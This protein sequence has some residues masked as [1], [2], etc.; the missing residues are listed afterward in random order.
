[1]LH[2]LS[3]LRARLKGF[4]VLSG[5]SGI[6]LISS[7]SSLRSAPIMF[8]PP[9][10]ATAVERLDPNNRTGG[11]GEDP[12][13][14]N[15]NVNIPVV[16]LRGRAELNLGLMLSYNSLVWTRTG[17]AIVF[18]SDNGFPSAGF[19]LGFPVIQQ[20]YFNTE[21]GKHAYLLINPD[22]SRIELRQVGSSVLFESGD[23]SH[24]LF[25]SFNLTLRTTDGAQLKYAL[26]GDQFNCTQIKD[27]NGNFITVNYLNNRIDTVID[28]LGRS[29]KFNYATNGFLTSITQIWNHGLANQSTHTWAAFEYTDLTIQTSFSS[30]LTVHGPTTAKLLTR[31][32]MPDGT[33]T[34][35]SYTSWGQ[36]WKV[37][38]FLG[39][40]AL[41]HQSYDVPLTAGT[42]LSDCP[43]FTARRDWARYWNGDTNGTAAANEEAV[44]SFIAPVGDSWTMPDGSSQTGRRAQVTAPDG[45]IDKIYF[46]GAAA[47]S[48]GWRRGLVALIET[49]NGGTW[50]RKVT[51]SW[52]QD[53]TS[54]SYP[55]NPREI[56]TNIYDPSGNRKRSE[57]TY[58]QF[59][60]SN[61]TSCHLPRDLYEYAANASTRLRSTRT[62]YNMSTSYTDRRIL[63]L[64]SERRLYQ[65]DVNA[66]GTLKARVAFFYDNENGANSIQGNNAPIQHDNTNYTSSFVTGR[67]NNSS[68]RR[69]N[70]D[71]QSQFTTSFSKYNTAGAVVSTKDASNHEVTISYTDSFSDGILR[72][73]LAYPTSVTDAD[74]FASTR[75][76]NF[77]FGAV[78]AAQTPQPNGTTNTPGP[79]QL[80]T[81]DSIGRLQ[82]VS[83]SVTSLYTRIEYSATEAR[84]DTFTTLQDGL[85]EA[86][87][88]KIADGH[89]RV[90][91]SATEHPGSSGGYRGQR[92][93]FDVMGR[94]IKTSNPAETAATGAPLQWTTVG[95]DAS[96]GWVFTEQTY[97][98]KGR[99]L[100]A[101][102]PSMTSNPAETTSKQI[103]YSSCGCAGGDVITVT[104][105]GT[106]D[107][108]VLKR[109]QQK[110]YKDVLGRVVKTETLNW[111]GG[112][113][114]STTVNS[115]D[116][117]DLITQSR[118]YAGAEGGATFQDTTMTYDGYGRLKTRH[119]PEQNVG[120]VTSWDY[121]ADD[122][123]QKITDARNATTTMSYN[124]RHL[125]TQVAY[126][127]PSPIPATPSTTYTYDAAGN[128]KS[129]TDASGTTTFQYSLLSQVTSE[130]RTFTG[131]S[132]SSFTLNYEYTL[133]G[134]LKSLT[135]HTNKKINYGYDKTG[136]LTAVTGTNYPITD[137]IDSVDYRAWNSPQQVVYGNGRSLNYSYNKRLAITN[138]EMPAAGSFG[139]VVDKEYEYYNDRR[140]KYSK[141][142]R[143]ER[144]DRS[145]N[146]DHVGRLARA[147]SGAEARGE[148][149][150]TDRPYNQF[151]TYDAFNHLAVHNSRHWSKTFPYI[152]SDFYTN[153][154]RNGWQYDA[155]GNLVGDTS[156]TFTFD[157]AARMSATSGGNISQ[158]F[159]GEGRRAKAIEPNLLTYYLVS[160]VTGMLV[161]TLDEIG[162]KK[163]GFVYALGGL[164]A[165]EDQNGFVSFVHK[166]ASAISVRKTHSITGLEIE[167]NELDPQGA[168][169]ELEDPYPD[170]PQYSGRNEGGPLYP[171]FGNVTRPGNCTVDGI[172]MPCDMAYRMLGAGVAVQ[173][174]ED[175]LTRYNHETKQFEFFRAYG[176]GF[177][178]Y[179]PAD[180]RYLGNGVA[181]SPSRYP[182]SVHELAG[183]IAL[184]KS[185]THF[186][187][188]SLVNKAVDYCVDD[189]YPALNMLKFKL[190]E[191][192]SSAANDDSK[193]GSATIRGR[194]GQEFDIVNDPTPPPHLIKLMTLKEARGATPKFGSPDG[195]TPFWT[196][197]CI[198]CGGKNFNPPGE[199]RYPELYRTDPLLRTQIHELGAA[200]TEIRDKYY[201]WIAPEKASTKPLKD[202]GL[203]GGKHDDDGPAM[204]DCVGRHYFEAS[205]LTPKW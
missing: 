203:Y 130:I 140:V 1:M 107:A 181:N 146:F 163:S 110:I 204:E 96:V 166:D 72:N 90:I 145:F 29:L 141:D 12:L 75:K 177:S 125:V 167:A 98:W 188:Y 136:R 79:Q 53:N 66:G 131:L 192:P 13:S 56:E 17:N 25:D 99:P 139:A 65:G 150:T 129:M 133:G 48:S 3:N 57:V 100:V 47:T 30:S 144:Y 37:S 45:R 81:Y 156:R 162:N 124:N 126:T 19:R 176:D 137:F 97:D 112:T 168:D 50:Q 173:V 89:G 111:A 26:M 159:D 82:R 74:L 122:T 113:V 116:V 109:R 180:A 28:T 105:E 67:A 27:R 9:P 164:M 61:G 70:V 200:L 151:F 193:N 123:I 42:V 84:E 11:G 22:G 186:I 49:H 138:L 8:L 158:V 102:N 62:D 148:G 183:V 54:V 191:K 38:S 93:V 101:T 115:Y 23:S 152:S 154:R 147:M 108:G 16:D 76:Y 114:Y 199:S 86:R 121:N 40:A 18:D 15:F 153:N 184:E 85:G 92:M 55:L 51:T 7:P 187:D 21:V 165:E 189:L 155:D 5:I 104:D 10:P 95:D 44:T 78:T 77:D 63:G 190:T 36:V 202:G 170:E 73:T 58:Q 128:R 88:F 106:L 161:A 59:N 198:P 135:D 172:W 179:L 41:K 195:G 134:N 91:A 87:S 31:I 117:R 6:L 52:T 20:I 120:A 80:L 171:G 60:F 69:Y 34:Q 46:I 68:V 197:S 94:P 64:V 132:G 103:S 157:A 83:N 143:D 205:K 169:T 182:D 39:T 194:N 14:R 119:R 2:R 175:G 201:P 24:L 71:D 142:N 32:T 196:Y 35:F 178:G 174:P 127:A 185:S 33:N 160:N 118:Q 43:R 149:T 4:V